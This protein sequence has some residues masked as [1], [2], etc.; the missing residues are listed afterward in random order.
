MV[1]YNL[2]KELVMIRY[3]RFRNERLDKVS[4]TFM[5]IKDIA[6]FINRSESYV[7]KRC[8]GMKDGL[9]PELKNALSNSRASK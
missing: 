9:Y 7:Q 3:L 6:K 8:N 4:H 2:Q 1:K 5:T